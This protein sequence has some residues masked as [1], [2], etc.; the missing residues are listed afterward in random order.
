M[1]N[2]FRKSVGAQ[3][4][5]SMAIVAALGFATVSWFSYRSAMKAAE[6]SAN[7]LALARLQSAATETDALIGH[8]QSAVMGI[9][10]RQSSQGSKYDPEM[11]KFINGMLETYPSGFMT[12]TSTMKRATIENRATR[13]TSHE[14]AIPNTSK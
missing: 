3:F 10:A 8:I 6:K 13:S 2:V 4:A 9:V 14:R 12:P 7:D 1:L 11:L 5:L